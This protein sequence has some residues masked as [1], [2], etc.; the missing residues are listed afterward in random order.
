[1]K[2]VIVTLLAVILATLS[3]QPVQAEDQRVLAIID[4][5]VNSRNIPQVIYEACF[6]SPGKTISC[7]NKTSFMEGKGSASAVTW[8]TSIQNTVYHGQNV[9]QSA[10]AINSNL[11]IVFIRVADIDQSTGNT[12]GSQ[13]TSIINAIKW[14]SDNAVKYSI[15]AVSISVSSIVTNNLLLCTTNSTLIN[16]VSNL[17]KQNIPVFAATGNDKSLDKVGFPACTLGIIGVG[18]YI[19]GVDKLETATNRGPGID[20]VAQNSINIPNVKSTGYFDFTATSAAT[21]IA[22]ALYVQ[23]T[24]YTTPDLFVNSFSKVLGL[25]PYISR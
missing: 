8:P 12:S 24:K 2:K 25:Y 7:P 18:A 1:M 21:P 4:S 19:P 16:S 13:P 23:Q 20:I 3:V 10:L 14:V 11:K 17:S 5:A 15:D 22:A 9:V 6:T